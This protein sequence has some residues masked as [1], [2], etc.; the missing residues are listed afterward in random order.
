MVVETAYTKHMKK[1]IT[2]NF[3]LCG[4]SGWCMECFWTGLHS[5]L[6]HTDRRLSCNT[7]IWMFPIYGMA[8]FISPISKLIKD[9][10][11]IIRGGVYTLCIFITEY[12]TGNILKKHQACP[13]DYSKAKLNYKGII[14]LDY[15]PVWFLVGLFYEKILSD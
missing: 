10:N 2:T 9:K 11:T 15:A 3:L 5:I 7:S 14:R 12:G 8:A 13:W 4:F 6:K 1:S